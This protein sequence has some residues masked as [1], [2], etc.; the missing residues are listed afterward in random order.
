MGRAAVH[1]GRNITWDEAMASEFQFNPGI[2]ELTLESE[3]PF[4]SDADGQYPVP[5]PGIWS[6]I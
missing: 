2:N 4:V 3:A 6:E 1:M 5:V